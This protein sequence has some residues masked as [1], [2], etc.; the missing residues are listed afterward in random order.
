[1]PYEIEKDPDA[2]SSEEPWAVKKEGGEVVACH[3]SEE[4][5]RKHLAALKANVASNAPSSAS[6]ARAGRRTR[7]GGSSLF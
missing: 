3:A 2:C 4:Q 6:S 1:M 5:A 7:P